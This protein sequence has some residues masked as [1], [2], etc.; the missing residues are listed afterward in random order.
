M[1]VLAKTKKHF[2]RLIKDDKGQVK[3]HPSFETF[4]TDW[5]TLLFSSDEALY[6]TL[7]EE[8]TKKTPP[9]GYKLLYRDLVDSLE[10]KTSCLL[11][12]SE[13]PLWSYGD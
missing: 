1:N 8:I 10:G 12:K 4:L 13:L 2:L 11:G 9:Y 7:L 3:R 5:N 6:D